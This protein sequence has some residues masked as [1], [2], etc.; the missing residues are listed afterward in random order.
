MVNKKEKFGIKTIPY[1]TR[2]HFEEIVKNGKTW[3]FNRRLASR[4]LRDVPNDPEC[5][6]PVNVY[7]PHQHRRL[8]Q[9]ELH[10][11]LVVNVPNSRIIADVPMEFFQKLPSAMKVYHGDKFIFALILSDSGE[12]CELRYVNF[13]RNVRRAMRQL[14]REA[15]DTRIRQFVKDH[16]LLVVAA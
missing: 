3:D 1:L 2:G 7:F 8:R 6:Y 10:I 11:R 15:K 13:D 4:D 14:I 5:L 16:L 9:C 12:P